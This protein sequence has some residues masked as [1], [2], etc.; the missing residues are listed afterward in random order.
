MLALLAA[1][2]IP[3]VAPSTARADHNSTYVVCPDPVQEGNSSRMGIRR[4]GYTV[5]SAYAFTDHRY[6]TADSDDYTE[7]HGVRFEQSEGK[8]LWF[9]IETTEDTR[10][11]HDETFA[12]GFWDGGVW[13]HCV[14]T[15]LDDDMPKI[16]GVNLVSSPI[17]QWA[18]R[19]GDTIDVAVRLDQKAEV[20]GSPLLALFLG[21]GDAST[22]WRGAGYLRGS[23]THELLF[24]YVVQP[25][26]LD[27]DGLSVGAAATSDDRTPAYG[28]AGTINA[29]G[30]DA[31]IDY[32]HSGIETMWQQRVDGRPYVQSTRIISVPEAGGQAYRANEVIE[33][34][35]TFD[36]RVVVE[37]D[38]CAILYV[39]YDGYLSEGTSREA[40]Y[41]RG[42]G[43]DT[44]VFGYTVRPGDT[45]AWGI[46]V[47]LGT[48][49]TGF[50]GRGTIKGEGTS[51][52]RNPWYLGLG[53]QREHKVDTAPP[54]ASSVTFESRPANGEAYAAGETI[55]VEVAF[56]EW[57]RV[58]GSP[59]LELDIG[60]ATR[61]AMPAADRGSGDRVVFEY[62][63]QDGDVDTDGIGI[64]AN[65]LFLNDGGFHDD[66]GNAAGVSHPAVTA[67]AGQRVAA[68]TAG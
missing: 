35:L 3:V 42:S 27:L 25:E 1:A 50:C 40:A 66:A 54:M 47:A 33:V 5:E 20:E 19:A 56:S 13:H 39:G 55:R 21:E 32:T 41:L 16:V 9:P 24:R 12:I 64:D 7:Y 60:D 68:S 4:S 23:G 48:E 6:Y 30:T 10:P 14:V 18:Y 22:T 15:I 65:S 36:T 52:E 49:T 63:V 11:E 53:H 61:R 29:A 67:D 51:V 34:A 59:Y 46:M 38:V 62:E 26:D 17:D 8:T 44:L 31:P 58:S 2:A 57:V 45:D 37:G 28:F 43:T